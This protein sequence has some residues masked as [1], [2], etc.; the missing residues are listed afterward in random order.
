MSRT[1]IREEFIA[2]QNNQK[3]LT[4]LLFSLITVIIWVTISIITSQRTETI[5]PELQELATP[6]NPNF[7][8]EVILQIDQR[9][10]YSDED[11]L[12]FPIYIVR[13]EDNLKS[14]F[15][16]QTSQSDSEAT[17]VSAT[18]SATIAPEATTQP[19]QT[20]IGPDIPDLP[21]TEEPDITPP[22]VF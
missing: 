9:R 18:N 14:V 4:I 10:E 7:P 5:E 20:P 21:T 2:L 8:D 16:S 3:L 22:T 12:S 1:S 11:L 17:T 15:F 19:T 13:D 6:L